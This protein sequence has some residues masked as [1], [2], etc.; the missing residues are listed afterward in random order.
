MR[1]RNL[2][3]MIGLAFDSLSRTGMGV[4]VGDQTTRRF[5]CRFS[6]SRASCVFPGNATSPH[7]R[8]AKLE[9]VA[10]AD[11]SQESPLKVPRP[12]RT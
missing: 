8:S 9:P 6:T 5:V 12:L 3:A 4:L 1:R 2:G 10:L 11:W 7:P